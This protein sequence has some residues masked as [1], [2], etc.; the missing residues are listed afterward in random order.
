MS[1]FVFGGGGTVDTGEDG[2]KKPIGAFFSSR[3]EDEGTH[4]GEGNP[5]SSQEINLTPIYM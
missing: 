3:A 5:M 2:W 1:S 4:L